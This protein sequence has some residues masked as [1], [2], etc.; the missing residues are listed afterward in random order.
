MMGTSLV[1]QMV[2]NSFVIQETWIWSLGWED[3][4]EKGTAT[5]SS[6][7]GLPWWSAGKESTCNVGDLGLIPGLGRSPREGNSY[8]LQCFCL[9]NST[10]RGAWQATSP[11]GNRVRHDWMTFTSFQ[12]LL[13]AYTKNS[14]N[15]RA[16]SSCRIS[17]WLIFFFNVW[18]KMNWYVRKNKNVNAGLE[19][20][21]G[22]KRV[23]SA[24]TYFYLIFWTVALVTEEP[25]L[26]HAISVREGWGPQSKYN[27]RSTPGLQLH[28][29]ALDV[30]HKPPLLNYI[31]SPCHLVWDF[32]VKVWTMLVCILTAYIFHMTIN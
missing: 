6:I 30:Y 8:P 7:L 28:F 18:A 20:S 12:P 26:P 19:I 2:K 15:S 10:D 13:S 22:W 1:A 14:M 4:L 5:H 27:S 31:V 11:R 3:P 23:R 16:H 21:A 9:E 17:C 24:L 29:L 25:A 32:G